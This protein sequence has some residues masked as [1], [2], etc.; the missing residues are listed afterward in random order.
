MTPPVSPSKKNIL[1]M[2]LFVTIVVFVSNKI[3]NHYCTIRLIRHHAA[4]MT[5]R[6]SHFIVFKYFPLEIHL[7]SMLI[8]T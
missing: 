8:Y 3:S 6:W 7:K 1:N 5:T 2:S 4:T